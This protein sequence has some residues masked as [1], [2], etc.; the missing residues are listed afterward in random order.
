V[1]EAAVAVA[2]AATGALAA[3]GTA[4]V[5]VVVVVVVVLRP[6][7]LSPAAHRR[8][9]SRLGARQKRHSAPL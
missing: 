1:A 2:V 9:R 3:V 6:A 7:E 5:V 8:P 4:A